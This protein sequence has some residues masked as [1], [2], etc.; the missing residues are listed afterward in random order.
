M[1][2]DHKTKVEANQAFDGL[3]ATILSKKAKLMEVLEEKQ[4][5]AEQKD[6]ALSRQVFL[7]FCELHMTSVKMEEVLKTE[8][9]FRLLQNLPS[10]PSATNTKHCYTERQ[11]LLQVEKV[12]RAVAKIEETLNETHGQDY[13]RGPSGGYGRGGL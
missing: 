2:K 5:A 12:C 6:K 11:S 9:E 7:E 10:I 3:V 4:E 8:D 13:Q 1:H